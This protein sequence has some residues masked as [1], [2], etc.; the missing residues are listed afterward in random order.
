MSTC[1][2][3]SEE[4]EGISPLEYAR[5]NGL[6]CNHLAEPI[7]LPYASIP[8][9]IDGGT[10]DDSHLYQLEFPNCSTDERPPLSRDAAMLLAWVSAPEKEESIDSAALSLL[11]SG[12]SKKRHLE[13]PLLK[14]DHEIDCKQFA[15]REGFEIKLADVKLPLEM[16]DDEKDEGLV[17]PT[18][19]WDK[20]SHIM[21]ELK[22]EKLPVTKGTLTYLSVALKVEWDQDVEDQVWA[23]VHTYKKVSG[24]DSL[25]IVIC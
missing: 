18:K 8:N 13:L 7:P 22:K 12:Q 6:A 19:L 20:G 25:D 24:A 11:G 15:R 17:F 16:V 10:T 2:Q 9:G 1:S 3:S 14:S 23:S 5:R 4:E 21:E